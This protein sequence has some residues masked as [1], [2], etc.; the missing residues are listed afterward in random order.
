MTEW[1]ERE[2][3]H[4]EIL[5]DRLQAL[6]GDLLR[7]IAGGS[8]SKIIERIGAANEAIEDWFDGRQCIPWEQRTV[9]AML[10]LEDDSDEDEGRGR[11]KRDMIDAAL[12]TV[13]ARMLPMPHIR[14][15]WF[16]N[17][18][19]DVLVAHRKKQREQ[20]ERRWQKWGVRSP[21]EQQAV[22]KGKR[23]G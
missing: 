3:R 15:D 14:D 16:D 19:I 20:M 18:E 13:S 6:A 2:Q 21:S 1:E 17:E 5:K 7:A 9:E 10:R 4:R 12:R 22:V 8:A 11:V 23:R